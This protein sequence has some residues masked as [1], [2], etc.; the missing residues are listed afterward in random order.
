MDIGLARQ[1]DTYRFPDDTEFHQALTDRNVYRKRVCFELLDRL[2]NDGSKEPTDTSNYSIEHILPQNEKL[3]AQE[4]S[5][6]GCRR[7][8]CRDVDHGF[9]IRA[10]EPDESASYPAATRA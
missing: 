5:S 4:P 1:R 7:V 3:P 2:E 6:E 10:N 9:P 8:F